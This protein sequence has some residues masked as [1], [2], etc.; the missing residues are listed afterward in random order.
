MAA[1]LKIEI[2]YYRTTS[3]FE[4]EFNLC[5]CCSMRMLTA[6]PN[7]KKELLNFLATAVNR[8]RVTIVVGEL[9]S[10]DGIINVVSS[11][12]GKKLSDAQKK[13]YKVPEQCSNLLPAGCVPLT[14]DDGILS[15]C[16]IESGPQAIILLSDDRKLRHSVMKNS[17]YEYVKLM[18]KS[19]NGAELA[20]SLYKG[21]HSSPDDV[22]DN[23]PAPEDKPIHHTRSLTP[24]EV[25]ENIIMSS[26]SNQKVTEEEIEIPKKYKKRGHGFL[27]TLICIF[28]S[29]VLT[30]CGCALYYFVYEPISA[31]RFYDKISKEN[32]YTL[33]DMNEDFFAVVSA[34]TLGIN[35]PVVM[36]HNVSYYS[37]H[38]FD[39]TVNRFGTPYSVLGDSVQNTVVHGFSDGNGFGKFSDYLDKIDDGIIGTAPTICLQTT[40]ESKY[41]TVF[42][43]FDG[44]STEFDYL[45][46]NFID[47]SEK[48]NFISGACMLDEA[49]TGFT[50]DASSEFLTIVSSEKERT[51]VIIASYNP[52]SEQIDDTNNTPQE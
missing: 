30:V 17:V 36:S 5:G 7:D 41:Y 29:I 38:L 48:Q 46:T 26:S 42:S 44:E 13:L 49:E 25:G 28:L 31:Q 21:K 6:K 37:T 33:S 40:D 24:E 4:M 9:F 23:T 12:I 19:E 51:V 20:A 15:G 52:K 45:C 39:G 2:L 18:S 32:A 47:D 1:D 8:S 50:P 22:V 43:V 16:I 3:D 34:H 10:S 11:A 35:F 14:C 27:Y